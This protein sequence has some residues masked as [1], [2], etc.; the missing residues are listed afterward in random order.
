MN[1]S[2]LQKF[3]SS[4]IIFSLL[5]ATTF[6][7][8]LLQFSLYA[9]SK[10]FF[11]I[12]AVVVE[13]EIYSDIKN[14]VKRYWEDIQWVLENTKVVILPTPWN[15]KAFKIASMLESL[16]FDWYNWLSKVDFESELIW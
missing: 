10:D 13:E 9:S 8:P 3:L 1:Y 2:K 7:I 14:Q 5:F 15:T 12:V 11:N 4:L 16:Y 6:R